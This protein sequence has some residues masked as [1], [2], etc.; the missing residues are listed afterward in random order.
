VQQ[1]RDDPPSTAASFQAIA[2]AWLLVGI[3]A[4]GLISIGPTSTPESIPP[5]VRIADAGSDGLMTLNGF[6]N[7]ADRTATLAGAEDDTYAAP[8]DA[9][10]MTPAPSIAV[11]PWHVLL[12][13][14]ISAWRARAADVGDRSMSTGALLLIQPISRETRRATGPA[15]LVPGW[16]S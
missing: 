7:E 2:V 9:Q 5:S 11:G 14:W 6:E 16:R 4:L 12:C 3:L 15:E 13:H 10:A 8:A 1:R